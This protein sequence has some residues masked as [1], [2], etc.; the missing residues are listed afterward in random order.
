M[1]GNTKKHSSTHISHVSVKCQTH[2]LM[3]NELGYVKHGFVRGWHGGGCIT[4]GCGSQQRPEVNKPGDKVERALQEITS[5]KASWNC[6]CMSADVGHFL[7]AGRRRRRNAMTVY[8]TSEFLLQISFHQT[9][10]TL[11]QASFQTLSAS[12]RTFFF[13]SCH[14]LFLE[15]HR[16]T[17]Y[18]NTAS[19]LFCLIKFSTKCIWSQMS[20]LKQMFFA[21][22]APLSVFMLAEKG[23]CVFLPII[24]LIRISRSCLCSLMSCV[25]SA[26]THSSQAQPPSPGLILSFC[27][28]LRICN[29]NIDIKNSWHKSVRLKLH[30][31]LIQHN[32]NGKHLQKPTVSWA[33]NMHLKK[34]LKFKPGSLLLKTQSVCP[35][36]TVT[37]CCTLTSS[38]QNTK[39]NSNARTD[40]RAAAHTH[41]WMPEFPV[42]SLVLHNIAWEK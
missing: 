33:Q 8:A 19:V 34:H 39:V 25:M 3:V 30:V 28:G 6:S 31:S 11:T 5:D 2:L 16:R 15:M 1:S 38:A 23:V 9:V 32:E 40:H 21:A 29:S 10:C 36:N 27:A 14:W 24:S 37:T 26:D 13:Q 7:H 4:R 35:H 41:T 42:E 17:P 20:V 22:S 12:Y 18:G